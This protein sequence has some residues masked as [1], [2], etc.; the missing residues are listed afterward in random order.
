M[1]SQVLHLREGDQ[2]EEMMV[3]KR[4]RE[5]DRQR[6]G[7]EGQHCAH[8]SV[9]N[10]EDRGA[11]YSLGSRDWINCPWHSEPSDKLP[12]VVDPGEAC[13][14]LGLWEARLIKLVTVLCSHSLPSLTFSFNPLR[15][16]HFIAFW[17]VAVP[18]S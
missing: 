6:V 8:G 10:M 17:P 15:C 4:K 14:T 9:A 5:K 18:Y 3:N 1:W 2:G 12:Q 7:Q 11:G 13:D 16:R